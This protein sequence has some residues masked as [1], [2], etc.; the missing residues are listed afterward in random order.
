MSENSYSGCRV[1]AFRKR[2]PRKRVGH[3]NGLKCDAII[4]G[5]LTGKQPMTSNAP[6]MVPLSKADIGPRLGWAVLVIVVTVG[7]LVGVN[8]GLPTQPQACTSPED[9]AVAGHINMSA[10]ATKSATNV[11]VPIA[12]ILALLAVGGMDLKVVLGGMGILGGIFGLAAQGPLRSFI[13]GLV[14]V[15]SRRFAVHDFVALD[16]VSDGPVGT[17]PCGVVTGFSLMTTTVQGLDGQVY[18]VSNGNIALVTNYSKNP[19]RVIVEARV[20]FTTPPADLLPALA[21]FCAGPL[22]LS[23]DLAGGHLL[24]PV[25]VKGV[26]ASDQFGYTVAVTAIAATP[27]TLHVQ[28]II[29]EQVLDFLAKFHIPAA[30]TNV[31]TTSATPSLKPMENPIRDSM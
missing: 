6:M 17:R 28:R 16:M 22:T 1:S 10:Q 31:V 21:E 11:L 18:F 26:V 29:R 15:T 12:A 24:R 20:A 23:K 14:I 30:T 8:L 27:S 3:F 5:R 9:C 25:V 19:Q 4:I 7:I 13:A 2:K